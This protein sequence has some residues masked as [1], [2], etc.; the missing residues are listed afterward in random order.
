MADRGWSH[1]P[2]LAGTGPQPLLLPLRPAKGPTWVLGLAPALTAREP[3]VPRLTHYHL[4]PVS[5]EFRLKQTLFQAP[6][7]MF[8]PSAQ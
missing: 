7:R 4:P 2:S 1:S 5:L 3:C 8:F 6:F